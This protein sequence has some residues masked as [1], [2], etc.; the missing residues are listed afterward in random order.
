M[1]TSYIVHL[2]WPGAQ[3]YGYTDNYRGTHLSAQQK[4]PHLWYNDVVFQVCFYDYHHC[5]LIVTIIIIL[6]HKSVLNNIN[7]SGTSQKNAHENCI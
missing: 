5:D 4:L 6:W 2:Y 1:K 7:Y 3:H